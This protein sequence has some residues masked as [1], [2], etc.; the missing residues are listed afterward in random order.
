MKLTIKLISILVLV[1]IASPII[2]LEGCGSNNSATDRSTILVN[3]ASVSPSISA[4]MIQDF[5]VTVRYSDGTPYPKAVLYISGPFAQPRNA[6]NTNPHYQFYY[7][8]GGNL[9]AGNIPVNSPFK[10]QTDDYGN[11]QFSILIPDPVLINGVMGPNTFSDTIDIFS[12]S[13]LV[14]IQIAATGS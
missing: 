3:P 11:Y 12:G 7:G 4:D 9:A 2:V 1:L 13:A 8:P 5:T 14:T 10:A 6:T